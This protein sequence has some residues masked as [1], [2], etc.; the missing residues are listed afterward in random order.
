MTEISLERKLPLKRGKIGGKYCSCKFYH[1][2]IM[3]VGII[4][5]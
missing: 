4:K 5:V 1:S 3:F 2:E